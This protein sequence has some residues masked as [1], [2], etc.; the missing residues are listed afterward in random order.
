MFR[1]IKGEKIKKARGNRSL[2]EVA[3]AAGHAFTDAALCSW[4]KYDWQKAQGKTAYKP[5]DDKIPALLA[6][7]GCSY[8]DISE[9]V[10]IALN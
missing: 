6:A 10:E 3:E 7:L 5:T 4:E 8:E 9:P 1:V 2:R